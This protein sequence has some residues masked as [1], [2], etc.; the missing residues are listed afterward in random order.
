VGAKTI[1]LTKFFMLVTSPLAFPLSKILDKILGAE[2]GTVYNRHTERIVEK[3]F[4]TTLMLF[5]GACR[6][7]ILE[8]NLKPKI[9]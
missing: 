1:W 8:K 9:S 7:M 4:V 3:K 5:S 6:K 2:I